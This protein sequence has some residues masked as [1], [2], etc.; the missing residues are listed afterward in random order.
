[1]VTASSNPSLAAL[2]RTSSSLL[3]LLMVLLLSSVANNV[4][5]EGLRSF[6]S[7]PM[8]VLAKSSSSQKH[9]Y[10]KKGLDAIESFRLVP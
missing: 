1:M 7:S 8:Q 5:F 3:L 6:L 4:P 2:V 10:S 9:W